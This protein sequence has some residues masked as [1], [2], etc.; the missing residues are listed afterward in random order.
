[1]DLHLGGKLALITGSTAGIGYAIAAAL[2]REGARVIVNGRTC[3]A[4]DAA[5]A[6]LT[7]VAAGAAPRG[8]AADLSTEDAACAIAREYP[9]V[10]ILINNLGIFEAKP[11]EDIPDADW[12]RLFEVNVLSGVRLARLYLAGMKRRN[13]GR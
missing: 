13:W 4:V 8:F 5:V 9:D 2:A 7:E 3:S 10:E 1:M 11:F 12:R 6:K